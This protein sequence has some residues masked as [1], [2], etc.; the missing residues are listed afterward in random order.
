MASTAFVVKPAFRH[1]DAGCRRHQVIGIFYLAE[2]LRVGEFLVAV[3][4]HAVE[5]EKPM[6]VAFVHFDLAGSELARLP[7]PGQHGLGTCAPRRGSD[8]QD[9]FQRFGIIVAT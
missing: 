4:G 2:A 7:V 9:I 6:L 1:V 8:A 5:F 3:I